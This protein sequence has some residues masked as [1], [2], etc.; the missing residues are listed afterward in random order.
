MEIEYFDKIV[1]EIIY[2]NNCKYNGD[3]TDKI[4]KLYMNC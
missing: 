4:M 2:L 3:V 1:N